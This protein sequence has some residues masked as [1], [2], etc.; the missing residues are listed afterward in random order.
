MG[1]YFDDNLDFIT[2]IE[3]EEEG[4]DEKE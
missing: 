3:S 4:E 2:I 1:R